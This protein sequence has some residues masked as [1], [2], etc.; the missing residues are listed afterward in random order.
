MQGP[1]GVVVAGTRSPGRYSQSARCCRSSRSRRSDVGA[2][3]AVALGRGGEGPI[4]LD[5]AATGPGQQVAVL[6]EVVVGPPVQEA[7]EA[8]GGDVL[9]PRRLDVADEE[10]VLAGQLVLEI[11]VVP[12]PGAVHRA[13]FDLVAELR[14]DIALDA[15]EGLAAADLASR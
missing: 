11:G 8:R 12:G 5:D 13:P 14:T 6:G 15:E 2:V 1:V 9:Q 7:G 3:D 4:G 10:R